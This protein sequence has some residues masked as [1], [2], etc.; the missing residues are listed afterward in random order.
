[1]VKNLNVLKSEKNK[2]EQELTNTNAKQYKKYMTLLQAYLTV[3]QNV[4]QLEAFE[5]REA[6][7]RKRQREIKKAQEEAEKQ[8]KEEELAKAET[9]NK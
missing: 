5:E 1:M 6:E 3:V 4:N 8:L 7:E 2:L 9:E